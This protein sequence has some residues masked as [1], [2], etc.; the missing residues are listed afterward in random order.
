MAMLTDNNVGLHQQYIE[1]EN[2]NKHK[3]GYK[4]MKQTDAS[5]GMFAVNASKDVIGTKA[6]THSTL[7]CPVHAHCKWFNQNDNDNDFL[8]KW[9]KS[10]NKYLHMRRWDE[11]IITKM[12]E[13]I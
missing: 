5:N 1:H 6:Y 12:S 9:N 7:G 3:H 8:T 10:D 11:K 2:D 13:E 4:Y